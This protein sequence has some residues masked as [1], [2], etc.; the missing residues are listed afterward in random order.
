MNH[1]DLQLELLKEI[2]CLKKEMGQLK[3]VLEQSCKRFEEKD[4]VVNDK[5]LEFEKKIDVKFTS[6]DNKI[7]DLVRIKWMVI[8]GATMISI[9]VSTVISLVQLSK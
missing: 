9:I 7:D 5:L 2:G 1:D 6:I 4:E 3:G 8:G